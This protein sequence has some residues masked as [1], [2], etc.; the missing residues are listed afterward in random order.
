MH[1]VLRQE[2]DR[3]D[4][5]VDVRGLGVPRWAVSNA[6]RDG[7]LERVHPGVY[8]DPNG[9]WDPLRAATLYIGERGALS[10]TTALSVWGLAPPHERVHA[11]VIRGTRLRSSRALVI[12]SRSAEDLRTIARQELKVTP[13]EDALVASWP[14]LPE[15][16]RTAALI[17]AVNQRMTLPSRIAMTMSRSGNVAERRA[18]LKL[19]DKLV[20]GCRSHLE[21][22]G[23][24]EVF[25]GLPHVQRQV[26]MVIG[27][28]TYY[29]DAYAES[30]R[31]DI[32]LDGASWHSAPEQRERDLRRDAAL[33]TVG[34]RVVRFSYRMMVSDPMAARAQLR[35]LLGEG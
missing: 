20:R 8:G 34:I 16:I 22:F 1:S 35:R 23:L 24:D 32:E 7:R 2:L 5:L 27:G 30:K 9:S 19:V 12:H 3:N 14:L 33:A 17:E 26:R 4:G 10:H 18:L 29:L 15:P 11:T 31:L 28:Q 21:L 25:S 13:V 6:L